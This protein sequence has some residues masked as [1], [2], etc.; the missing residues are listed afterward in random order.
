MSLKVNSRDLGS[1]NLSPDLLHS[2]YNAMDGAVTIT[3]HTA[4]LPKIIA[5]PHASVSYAFVRAMQGPAFSM[6][7]DG[8][9]IQPQVRQQEMDRYASL[10]MEAQALLDRL[11]NTVWGPSRY[12]EVVRTKELYTPIGKRGQQLTPRY[13]TV[14]A[15]VEREEPL[16]LNAASDKQCLAF[17]NT[18]L[19]LP[20]EHELRKTPGGTIRTPTANSKAL[21]KWAEKK[22][23]GPGISPRDKDVP[24]VTLAAPFVSL[25]LTIRDADKMLQVLRTPVDSDGRMRCSYNVAGTENG[26]WSSSKNVSGRGTNLQNITPSMRR[27]FCA[28][29]N[30]WFISTDLE[31][32]ESRVVAGLVWQA[33]GDDGYLNACLSSD[34][35]TTVARMTWPELGWTDDAK[36]NR[37]IANT[38]SKELPKFSYRD[39]AKRLGHGSNY[40]GSPFG[41][42]QAVGIPPNLV[43]DFQRRYFSAFPAIPRWHN[44]TKEHLVNHQFLD[45]PLGRRRW[46]FSRPDEDATLREAIAFVPQSTVGELLNLIM[47]RCWARSFK[48]DPFNLNLLHLPIKLLLQNHDAFAFQTPTSVD[49]PWIISQVNEEFTR[50]AIPLSRN[51]EYKELVIPGEFVAGWNWAYADDIRKPRGEWTFADGNPDGLVKW[52]GSDTRR[53]LQA[54]R[55]SLGDWLGRSGK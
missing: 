23:K 41:I 12:M 53:R 54:T 29:D 15:E 18:A 36:E 8:I 14:L 37:K 4:L 19:G 46:F 5:S 48:N 42:A 11:A 13:R 26:R 20:V 25:I 34:L 35:H 44:W 2:A 9:A 38:P 43:E 24:Y 17:F 10:K 1:M 27:M 22:L 28:D 52:S 30:H 6:M 21:R 3:V 32:A 31:Q 40:R 7:R 39:I 33:T 55:P 45:T 49:L 50:A 16:G 51:G 47:W